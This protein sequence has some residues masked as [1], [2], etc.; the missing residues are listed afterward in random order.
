MSFYYS[1]IFFFS[2]PFFLDVGVEMIMPSLSTLLSD[3]TWQV[4]GNVGPIF[5]AMLQDKAH[6]KFVFFF[7]LCKLE[8]THGP[9]ISFGLSTFCHL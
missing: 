4:F 9:L 3:T 2:P 1:S 8:Y 6:N 7:C 5:S